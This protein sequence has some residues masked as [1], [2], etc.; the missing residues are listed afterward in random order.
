MKTKK[1]YT[2]GNSKKHKHKTARTQTKGGDEGTNEGTN[3]PM[4][5]YETMLSNVKYPTKEELDD[6]N[7][8]ID[9]IA[10]RL[11][12]G[13]DKREYSFEDKKTADIIINDNKENVKLTKATIT[14]GYT[15]MTPILNYLKKVELKLSI[16]VLL[17]IG[18]VRVFHGCAYLI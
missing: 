14:K 17:G 6:I 1:H 7:D 15:T 4:K 9:N 2:R 5:K 13:K 11:Y 8:L 16:W 12:K 3:D 10:N 18:N